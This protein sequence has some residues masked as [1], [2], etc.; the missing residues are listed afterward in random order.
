MGGVPLGCMYLGIQYLIFVRLLRF[1]VMPFLGLVC[2]G[3]FRIEKGL[4]WVCM[5]F[6]G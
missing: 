1:R 5:S 2:F 6:E 4:I 3:V